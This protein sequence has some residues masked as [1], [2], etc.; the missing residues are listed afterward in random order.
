MLWWVKYIINFFVFLFLAFI[1]GTPVSDIGENKRYME[2]PV[3]GQ[4]FT[5]DELEE[6]L[7]VWSKMNNSSLRGILGQLSLKSKYEYPKELVKWLE[8]QNWN[9]DRFF[10]NEQRLTEL[11]FFVNLKRSI[12]EHEKMQQIT[13]VNLQNIIKEQQEILKKSSFDDDEIELI[14]KNFVEI[15]KFMEKKKILEDLK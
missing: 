9:I 13:N 5:S 10:Y 14:T 6:F 8:V 11:I 4:K 12:A 1:I 2:M 15:N 3:A 7:Y